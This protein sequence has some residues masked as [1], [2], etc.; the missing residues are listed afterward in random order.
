MLAERPA[1]PRGR[2]EDLPGGGVA[3]P[4]TGPLDREIESSLAAEEEA[5]DGAPAAAASPERVALAPALDAAGPVGRAATADAPRPAAPRAAPSP[6][7]WARD[8]SGGGDAKAEA[9]PTTP[10][11]A[12]KLARNAIRAGATPPP[13]A[14]APVPGTALVVTPEPA[15]DAAARPMLVSR[16]QRRAWTGV[17][18]AVVALLVGGA[19][20]WTLTAQL[21]PLMTMRPAAEAEVARAVPAPSPSPAPAPVAEPAP[22]TE[23]APPV[24]EPELPAPPPAVPTPPRAAR[25]SVLPGAGAPI[26][27]SATFR[28]PVFN[29]TIGIGGRLSLVIRPAGPGGAVRVRFDASNGLVGAGELTG[30]LSADGYLTASGTLMMGRNPFECDLSGSV[31]G[32]RLNGSARFVRLG[33]DPAN[34]AV[35][36]SRFTLVRS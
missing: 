24:A 7:V 4:P 11:L 18:A 29:E 8:A 21:R 32:E 1:G 16:P 9:A 35:T 27:G 14:A 34:K 15:P 3:P 13:E 10:A 23:A 19:A 31:A 25:P 17:F 36:Q 26:E 6:T 5:L 22:V 2:A 12:M 28:G 33:V 30:H 20:G